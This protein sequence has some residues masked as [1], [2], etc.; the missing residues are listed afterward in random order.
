MKL[1]VSLAVNKSHVVTSTFN[2]AVIEYTL[3]SG[4]NP[5]TMP[6]KNEAVVSATIL[7]DT[8]ISTL[9]EQ[10]SVLQ[11][12]KLNGFGGLPATRVDADTTPHSGLLII[13]STGSTTTEVAE[14]TYLNLYFVVS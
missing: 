10:F 3:V 8:S 4:F 13:S 2:N 5:L 7:V 6:N 11:G 12:V 1:E 14:G 9:S